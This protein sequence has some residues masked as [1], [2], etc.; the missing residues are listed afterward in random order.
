LPTM[1][2]PAVMQTSRKNRFLIC[3]LLPAML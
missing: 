2:R 1:F 3:F